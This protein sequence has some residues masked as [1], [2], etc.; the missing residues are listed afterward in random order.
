MEDDDEVLKRLEEFLGGGESKKVDENLLR[1]VE[2]A[3]RLCRGDGKNGRNKNGR[4]G[5]S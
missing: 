4:E 2:I 1:L 3:L 5:G